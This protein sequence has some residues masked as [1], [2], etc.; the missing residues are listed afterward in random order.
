MEISL[1]NKIIKNEEYLQAVKDY[2]DCITYE[3]NRIKFDKQF[4]NYLKDPN[5]NKN[6][7][8]QANELKKI[9]NDGGLEYDNFKN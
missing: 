9:I 7:L 2:H 4:D 8:N 1:P 3:F 5:Y 6:C